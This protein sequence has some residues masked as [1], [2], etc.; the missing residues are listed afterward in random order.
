MKKLLIVFFSVIIVSVISMMVVYGN[1]KFNIV[2]GNEYVVSDFINAKK[3]SQYLMVLT[4][5]FI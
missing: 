3:Y 1:S 4:V 5:F 2:I